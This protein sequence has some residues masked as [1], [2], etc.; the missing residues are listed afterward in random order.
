MRRLALAL[1]A[2]VVAFGLWVGGATPARAQDYSMSRFFYYPYYYYPH[3]Y[4]PTAGPRWP[5]PPGAPYM[6]PPAYMTYP[7]F[8]EPHWRYDWWEAHKHLKPGKVG[9]RFPGRARPA[10]G[11]VGGPTENRLDISLRFRYGRHP[12]PSEVPSHA[13]AE[14]RCAH[15]P[16][17]G[18][19]AYLRPAG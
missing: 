17:L 11:A 12:V 16:A 19:G 5:E 10:A 9:P 2:G 18:Y 8:R 15:R 6:R 1:W 13:N 14:Q 7:A 4:W 3:S